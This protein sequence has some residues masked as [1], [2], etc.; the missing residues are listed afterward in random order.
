MA[1]TINEEIQFFFDPTVKL[2]DHM[3][4]D[5]SIIRAAQVSVTGE[6]EAGISDKRRAGLI[7]YLM[8]QKHGSPYEQTSMTFYVKAPIFVFREFMRHRI[9]FSYNEMSG[10]Y[11]QLK[12]HFYI[13]KESR[14]L[15]NVGS[16]AHPKF[17]PGDPQQVTAIYNLLPY[18]YSRSWE[19]YKSLIEQGIG[20]EVARLVLPVG[21]A[22]EMYVTMNARSLMSFLSL[23]TH[24]E[25]ATFVSNPQHE[26]EQVARR[27]EEQ[28]A[29]LFPLTYDSFNSNGRV[30]P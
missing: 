24:D 9:G 4:N 27:I 14:P 3:G 18:S 10:R 17:E 19:A 26:I 21:I 20:N 16:G 23:R 25:S 5:D 1:T 28:F 30:A 6:N 11:T 29:Q 12:P 8:K 7:N 15:V 2:I 13:P 22:S